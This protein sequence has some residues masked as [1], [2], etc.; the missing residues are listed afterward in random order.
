MNDIMEQLRQMSRM[1]ATACRPFPEAIDGEAWSVEEGIPRVD[2]EGKR[3]YVP[4]GADPQE[5]VSRIHELAH[6]K[7]TPKMSLSDAARD[8]NVTPEAM[9]AAE[10][11][12][13]NI[14][15]MK[16]GCDLTAGAVDKDMMV[17]TLNRLVQARNVGRLAEIAAACTGTGDAATVGAWLSS[18]EARVLHPRIPQLIARLMDTIPGIYQA[19]EYR[20]A[21]TR[22]VA[23]LVHQAALHAEQAQKIADTRKA[24][25]G[26]DGDG[27]DGADD[28]GDGEPGS[29]DENDSADEILKTAE[30]AVFDND[31]FKSNAVWGE[32]TVLPTALRFGHAGALR[33]LR[34]RCEESGA[35]M[36]RPERMFIDGRIFGVRRRAPG[37]SIL[38]DVSGSMTFTVEQLDR[39]L[40][41]LPGATVGVYSNHNFA[42][43]CRRGRRVSKE[44]VARYN[45]SG[46]NTCDGPAL[47][48]L[49]TQ[50]APRYWISDGHINGEH[51]NVGANLYTEVAM[52]LR[53]RHIARLDSVEEVPGVK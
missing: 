34:P 10:D 48:W 31:K 9:N 32:M 33:A 28:A 17:L 16:A 43:V 15:A 35:L 29:E 1:S 24:L 52:T 8:S 46:Y 21:G 40:D 39:I 14:L 20:F 18:E 44:D 47:T 51:G 12:R 26:D 37:G 42:L 11:G 5:R 13:V 27:T 38:I 41:R 53:R 49:G 2:L 23:T 45:F 22:H 25:D 19:Y 36:T 4:L 7:W 30:R 3:L 50:R 6:I